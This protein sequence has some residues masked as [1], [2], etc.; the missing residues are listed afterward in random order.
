[1][2]ATVKRQKAIPGF[3]PTTYAVF[4]GDRILKIFTSETD[5]RA[6]AG[7]YNKGETRFE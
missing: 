5:A 4:V 1:M 6:F 7:N 2:K 3:L